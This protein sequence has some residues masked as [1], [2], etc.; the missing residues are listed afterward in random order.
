MSKLQDEFEMS[1]KWTMIYGLYNLQ[2]KE[3]HI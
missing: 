3:K 1:S 2:R